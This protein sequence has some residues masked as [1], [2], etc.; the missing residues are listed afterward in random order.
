[1]SGD[2][3]ISISLCRL[4]KINEFFFGILFIILVVWTRTSY[5][6]THHNHFTKLFAISKSL[7][8]F[9]VF[10]LSNLN[11]MISCWFFF[12]HRK[13]FPFDSI[14]SHVFVDYNHIY[15]KSKNHCEQTYQLKF[16]LLF[17][18]CMW[19]FY[20]IFLILWLHLTQSILKQPKGLLHLTN[21]VF[22]P[23]V[24]SNW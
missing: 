2:T 21:A 16:L 24:N 5:F 14:A 18:C 10:V 1:M 3:S 8:F 7:V 20:N 22:R 19:F 12:L 9:L 13:R 6:F 23:I 15:W 17:V 4:L 11:L